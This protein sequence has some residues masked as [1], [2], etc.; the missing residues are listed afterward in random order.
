M[1]FFLINY[2]NK[3][4]RKEERAVL[5]NSNLEN[6]EFKKKKNFN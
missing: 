5:T 3:K 4:Y 6:N 2:G 1:T